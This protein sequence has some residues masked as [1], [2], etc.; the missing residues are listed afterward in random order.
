MDGL[1]MLIVSALTPWLLEQ[2]KWQRWFPLMQPFAPFLNRATP[3]ALAGAVAAGITF[4]V[5]AE[6]WT[7]RGPLPED[8]VRGVLLW[9]VGAATQHFAYHRA[10]KQ[11]A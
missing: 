10:I 3:L 1:L 11:E 8:M 6:G 5:D 4:T 7:L 2:L 9:I